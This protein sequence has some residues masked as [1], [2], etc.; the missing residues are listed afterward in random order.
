MT[1]SQ[2][3]LP[4]CKNFVVGWRQEYLLWRVWRCHDY[5]DQRY[6]Q[7]IETSGNFTGERMIA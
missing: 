7:I 4:G 6:S 3:D 2:A 1:C 5:V